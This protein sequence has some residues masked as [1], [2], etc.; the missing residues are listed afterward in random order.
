MPTPTP[1]VNLY[2][3]AY[4]HFADNAMAEVRR[5]TYG[6]DIGQSS[7]TTADEYR[8]F[9]AALNLS[10][11]STVL[12]LGCGSGG[13]A[14]F[15]ANEANC[16]V[17][18]CDVNAEGIANATA[19]ARS[20]NL[21]ARARFQQTQPGQPLP[22]PDQSLDAIICIDAIIHIP[23]RPALLAD[24]RRILKPAGR[25]LYTNPTV[26]TGL[27]S[28]D[29]IAIRASIGHFDF[30]GPDVDRALIA[31]AGLTLLETRD[32]TDQAARISGRWHDARA[33]R[34]EALKK[35]ESPETFE[36]LQLFLSTVHKLCKERRLARLVFVAQR[37]R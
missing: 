35:L 28:K 5:D 16:S 31:A 25:L 27:V 20:R 32:A 15:L 30:A 24:C 34:A 21:E 7:W 1:Q 3:N 33:K 37:D 18:G 10:P 22:F 26:L 6:D 13:P 9:I 17:V 8:T 4:G 29:E 14:L 19:L 12:D 11:T 23:D 2:D 36:G